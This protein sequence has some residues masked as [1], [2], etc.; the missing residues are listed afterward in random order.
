[1]TER[2]EKLHAFLKDNPKDC[3]LNH[4]LALEYIK[5]GDWANA[6]T[7]FETNLINDPAYIATYY[8]L[9]KL[10]ESQGQKDRAVSLYE[11]GMKFAKAAKDN[12]TY[13]ELQGAYDDLVY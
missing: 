12:H 2:I 6:K 3:F 10:V 9:G 1:M 13:N 7:H 4:A 5:V 11:T 8:H